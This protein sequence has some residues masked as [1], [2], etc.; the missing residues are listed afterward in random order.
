MQDAGAGERVKLLS[1]SHPVSRI[2]PNRPASIPQSSHT[3]AGRRR[4]ALLPQ[5]VCLNSLWRFR[6]RHNRCIVEST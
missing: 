2:L 6:L 5:W 1:S 4:R 3:F